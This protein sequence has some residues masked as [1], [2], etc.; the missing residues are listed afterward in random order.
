MGEFTGIVLV[1]VFSAGAVVVGG[2]ALGTWALKKLQV[3]QEQKYDSCRT[4]E[5]DL[6]GV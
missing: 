5:N 6:R 4:F 2:F 3:I 1:V